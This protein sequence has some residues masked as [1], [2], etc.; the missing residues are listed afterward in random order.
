VAK[1]FYEEKLHLSGFKL[2]KNKGITFYYRRYF[3]ASTM[4]DHALS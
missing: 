2:T 1:F 3:S 4:P